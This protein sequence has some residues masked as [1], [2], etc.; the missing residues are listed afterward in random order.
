MLTINFYGQEF[1]DLKN[2]V[3]E[4]NDENENLKR[5]NKEQQ[6]E[7]NLLVQENNRL[8]SEVSK[9][10]TAEDFESNFKLLC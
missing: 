2:K 4:L 6:D 3:Y 10:I 7:I 5:I 8:T 9:S 1:I